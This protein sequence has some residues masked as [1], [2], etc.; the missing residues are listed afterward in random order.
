MNS[1]RTRRF[2]NIP[3]L[4]YLPDFEAA[5]RPESLSVEAGEHIVVGI[6]GSWFARQTIDQTVIDESLPPVVSIK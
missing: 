2:R 1:I 3:P 6:D 4:Q 5:A